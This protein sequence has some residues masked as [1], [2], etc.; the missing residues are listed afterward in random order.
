M[1]YLRFAI[2]HPALFRT[3]HAP[4]LVASSPELIEQKQRVNRLFVEL[5]EEGQRTGEL[6]RELPAVELAR[7]F[8]ALAEGLAHQCIEA[9]GKAPDPGEA[10]RLFEILARSVR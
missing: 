10:E 6:Q 9:P 2:E 5:V 3:M 8:T 7:L 1:S 4:Q